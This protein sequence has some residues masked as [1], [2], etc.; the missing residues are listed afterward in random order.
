MVP[1]GMLREALQFLFRE[2]F[3]VSLIFRGNVWGFGSF[4]ASDGH[5]S[6]EVSGG[7]DGLWFIHR[8]WDEAGLF[9]IAGPKDNR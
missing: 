6:D 7:I 2:Y 5:F 1:Y 4:C 3:C 9:G 8:S